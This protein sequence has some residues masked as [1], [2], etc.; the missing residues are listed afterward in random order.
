ML[1]LLGSPSMKKELLQVIEGQ[2]AV[3]RC[4]AYI[5]MK[6]DEHPTY[7][8][9]VNDEALTLHVERVGRLLLGTEN[10]IVG[11]KVM[12]S[13]DFAF[14]QEQIPGFMLGIGI[15]NKDVG[16]VHSPHSPYFFLDEDVLPIGA[17][18]H[19]A[20]AEVYLSEHQHSSVQ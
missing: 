16:S 6:E 11:K 14:Y 2:A 19:A 17:A 10:V 20:L 3:H 5:D 15:G 1:T 9:V 7:P 12:A 8:A 18:V 13:E 4:K